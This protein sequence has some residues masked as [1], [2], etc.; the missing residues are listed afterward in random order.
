[1]TQMALLSQFNVVH[2]QLVIRAPTVVSNEHR[3]ESPPGL[4]SRAPRTS[5]WVR[6]YSRIQKS[7]NRIR[8]LDRE[9]ELCVCWFPGTSCSV[10]E[11]LTSRRP[12]PPP[13]STRS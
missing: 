7:D 4:R 12:W 11:I 10:N 13:S 8:A 6:L 1:M 5:T 9:L 2:T 3:T